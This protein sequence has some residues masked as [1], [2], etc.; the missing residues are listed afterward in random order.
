MYVMI[1]DDYFD[2]FE[3][4]SV[5]KKSLYLMGKGDGI[6]LIRH[7]AIHVRKEIFKQN[8]ILDIKTTVQAK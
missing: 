3:F 2:R 7:S 6:S 4:V 8:D 1:F 5:Q